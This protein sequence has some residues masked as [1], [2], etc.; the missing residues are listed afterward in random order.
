MDSIP[1]PVAPITY[2]K[3]KAY[4]LGGISVTGLQKFSEE[5]VK[6]FSGLKVGQEIRLPGDKLTSAI[7]KLYEQKQFSQVDVYISKIDGNVVYL[8]F[9]VTELP[10][11]NNL[12]FS[13]VKKSKAK[14]LRKET[15]L[16]MGTML[17]DN[18]LVTTENYIRKKYQEKGFLNTKVSLTTKVDTTLINAQ[19]M[20]IYV[21]KGKKVKIKNINIDGNNKVSDKALTKAM[22]N[23]KEKMF[24]RFWKSSKFIKD[25]YEEDLQSLLDK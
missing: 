10:Q 16:Q 4:E 15:E 14:E 18:L 1:Q 9:D 23:T 5:A 11:L 8:E 2:E 25:D 12:T 24:G 20:M 17:T 3:N 22:K 21:D 6:V 7:K 19:N 13:G